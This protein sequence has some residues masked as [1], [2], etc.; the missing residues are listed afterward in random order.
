MQKRHT[1]NGDIIEDEINILQMPLLPAGASQQD[2][3]ELENNMSPLFNNNDKNNIKFF[4]VDYNEMKKTFH[5]P[6]DSANQILFY[7]PKHWNNTNNGNS[8]SNDQIRYGKLQYDIELRYLNITDANDPLIILDRIDIDDMIGCNIE[9]SAMIDNNNDTGHNSNEYQN[10]HHNDESRTAVSNNRA[11]NE[12]AN[13]TVIDTNGY[14]TLHIYA[15]PRKDFRR[16]NQNWTQWFISIFGW[17]KSLFSGVKT[18]CYGDSSIDNNCQPPQP[19][20]QRPSVSTT[21][22]PYPQFGDRYSHHRSLRLVPVEDMF[23]VQRVVLALKQLATPHDPHNTIVSTTTTLNNDTTN[24]KK[25]QQNN[26]LKYLVLINPMSG[27]KKNGVFVYNDIVKPILEQANID[28]TVIISTHP[29]HAME[30]CM[31]NTSNSTNSSDENSTTQTDISH[32]DALI[33][34]GGDGIIHEV[35]NGIEQRIDKDMIYQTIKLGIIGC[36]TANGMASSIAYA[37]H[38]RYGVINETFLIVKGYTARIDLS[39]YEILTKSSSSSLTTTTPI[40]GNDHSNTTTSFRI[41][42]YMSCLTYTWAL[43][44]D[45][46]IESEVIHWLGPLRF[47]IWAVYRVLFL[48]RY[49]AKLSYKPATSGF[50]NDQNNNILQ[51]EQQLQQRPIPAITEPI[52]SADWKTINDDIVAIWVSHVTHVCYIIFSYV[53]C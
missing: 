44:S 16:P 7:I 14:A 24:I 52:P 41:A 25:K 4:G 9:I 30:I 37:S 2:E 13:D 6:I 50:V 8:S 15:Y 34:M 19:H 17:F 10:V 53:A 29:K 23:H 22:G 36:G 35:I 21:V 26:R 42:S 12:P 48:R 3:G 11:T 27:P 45:I 40:V 28:T 39:K 31:T 46:D 43:I 5:W 20:Y 18:C 49:K 47:D 33:L 32:Y 1:V 51:Q 38:E